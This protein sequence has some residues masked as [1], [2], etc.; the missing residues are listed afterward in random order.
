MSTR[1]PRRQLLHGSGGTQR[2]CGSEP[3]D[4]VVVAAE[5][6]EMRTRLDR[7]RMSAHQL[8]DGRV[9]VR[10]PRLRRE[11]QWSEQPRVSR[12]QRSPFGRADLHREQLEYHTGPRS[13]EA[14]PA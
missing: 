8:D 12:E 4:V 5:V 7:G 2:S 6:A 14:L 1:L 13:R 11:R 3:F 10:L 9:I